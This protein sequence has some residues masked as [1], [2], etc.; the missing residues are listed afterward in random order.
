MQDIRFLFLFALLSRA[1][2]FSP[3]VEYDLHHQEC[4]NGVL[5][6][7]ASFGS[8]VGN[9][10]S[11]TSPRCLQGNGVDGGGYEREDNAVDD[12]MTISHRRHDKGIMKVKDKDNHTTAVAD[13][14]N[15]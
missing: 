1:I 11:K 8:L 15:S 4:M 3:L 7:S 9:L 13:S 12:G 2:A 10:V 5:M 6:D 14:R